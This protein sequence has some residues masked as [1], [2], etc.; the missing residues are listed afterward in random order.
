MCT[1][2]DKQ[3]KKIEEHKMNTEIKLFFKSE[4]L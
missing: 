4:H 1:I 3:V 2:N